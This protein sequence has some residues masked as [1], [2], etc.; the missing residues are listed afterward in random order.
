MTFSK[1][2][3]WNALARCRPL[4]AKTLAL[5]SAVEHADRNVSS[6]WRSAATFDIAAMLSLST[7]SFPLTSF[8]KRRW[9]LNGSMGSNAPWYVKYV[10]LD[11]SSFLITSLVEGNFSLLVL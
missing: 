9:L 3:I 1:L 6:N 4:L 10:R 5:V 7:N 2:A 8:C 11:S